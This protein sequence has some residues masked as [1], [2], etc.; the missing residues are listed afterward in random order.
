[1]S[2]VVL[3][4]AWPRRPAT[5]RTSTPAAMSRVAARCRVASL[6]L[7]PERP[8][9]R[10][11]LS[12]VVVQLSGRSGWVPPGRRENTNASAL[13]SPPQAVAAACADARC[14]RSRSRVPSS[15]AT[16]RRLWVLVGRSCTPP[17]TTMTA[18]SMVTVLASTSTSRQRRAQSSPRRAPVAAATRSTTAN[19]G[20]WRSAASTRRANSSGLGGVTIG[21]WTVGGSAQL[22]GFRLSH[23]HRTARSSAARATRWVLRI[24]AGL[25][26]IAS[27]G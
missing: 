3:A 22:A 5:V 26:L 15:S 12:K 13:S 19:S 17:S 24:V 18:R 16:V 27:V 25:R 6:R 7:K 1:M 11:S 23:P 9:R 2:S 21:R 4:R 20:S 8:V 14:W 10:S